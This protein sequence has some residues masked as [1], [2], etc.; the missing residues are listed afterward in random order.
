MLKL[1]LVVVTTVAAALYISLDW[2]S[3]LDSDAGPAAG[4]ER[5]DSLDVRQREDARPLNSNLQPI[6]NAASRDLWNGSVSSIQGLPRLGAVRDRLTALAEAGDATAMVALLE[7][8]RSCDPFLASTAN[9]HPTQMLN[10]LDLAPAERDRRSLALD[11]LAERCDGYERVG[12]LGEEARRWHEA[13]KILAAEGNIA[14]RAYRHFKG[15][16]ESSI[17]EAYASST[18]PWVVEQAL[19]ALIDSPRGPA[20]KEVDEALFQNL[21]VLGNKDQVR[22]IQRMAARWRACE[23]G[24]ACGVNQLNEL[25]SC[26]YLG[27]CGLGMDVRTFVRQRSLST[28]QFELMQ[29]YLAALDARVPRQGRGN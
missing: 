23:L 12:A 8:V 3:P 24:A 14:A 15:E 22:E 16:N 21:R 27:N 26:V 1:I 18:D 11:F 17:L 2:R 6:L 4:E 19:T 9:S 28:F 10:S 25:E 20:L 7:I 29:Q 5:S 13:L